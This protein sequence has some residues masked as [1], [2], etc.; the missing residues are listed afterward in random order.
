M[1]DE[2]ERQILQEAGVVTLQTLI[3]EWDPNINRLS[4]SAIMKFR[5]CPIDY[6]CE[7]HTSLANVANPYLF[8]GN[9]LHKALEEFYPNIVNP[10]PRRWGVL[11]G[12]GNVIMEEI[13][14][15]SNLTSE[16]SIRSIGRYYHAVLTLL[17][18][19]IHFDKV[20]K[21]KGTHGFQYDNQM[22]RIDDLYDEA[23]MSLRKFAYE[24][25]IRYTQTPTGHFLPYGTEM[26]VEF[27]FPGVPVKTKG[28]LDVM[29]TDAYSGGHIPKD[30]KNRRDPK[31]K[32]SDKVQG[33][34]Y[35]YGL[36][37]C[38][39]I[40]VDR[41]IFKNIKASNAF[42]V[43]QAIKARSY[44]VFPEHTVPIDRDKFHLIESI[45][46]ETYFAMTDKKS[47]V[48]HKDKDR[49]PNSWFCPY[50]AYCLGVG[51]FDRRGV[52]LTSERSHREEEPVNIDGLIF[53]EGTA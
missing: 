11:D 1:L 41:F 7:Y 31:G 53:T 5:D 51:M 48:V 39:G 29:F 45:V 24:E 47:Y 46:K 43:N 37:V 52:H 20:M 9:A 23:L 21:F 38:F 16:E 42:G 3:D 50:K 49:C 33:Y 2:L 12:D 19:K 4:F 34:I 32:Q 18:S 10:L 14:D 28:F 36:D 25:A 8:M 35:A 40:L 15:I 30:Y 44:P 13:I 6:F 22:K 27:Q 26:K 17:E